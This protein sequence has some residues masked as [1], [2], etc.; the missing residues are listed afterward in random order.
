MLQKLFSVESAI[1][2]TENARTLTDAV[3]YFLPL[4]VI[5]IEETRPCESIIARALAEFP[6]PTIIRGG[7]FL[8]PKP[9]ST[10]SIVSI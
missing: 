5:T 6:S 8:Y 7:A 4:F 3:V 2:K 10:I 1:T 9:G